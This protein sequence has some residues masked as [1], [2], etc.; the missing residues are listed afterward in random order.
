MQTL[1]DLPAL[2]IADLVRQ[3]PGTERPAV[4]GLCLDVAEGE[5]F[6]LLGPNG[7]GKTTTISIVC[8]LLQVDHGAVEVVGHSAGSHTVQR[9][10]GFVPQDIALYDTLT[11]RENLRFFGAMYDLSGKDLNTR[12]NELLDRFGLLERADDQIRFFSGGMKRRVNIMAA[13]LHGPRLLILDEPTVG[14]DVQ[15]RALINSHLSE[16]NRSGTTILYTSH[17]LD[18][19]ER[20]CSR[21]AIMD[22][23]SIIAM[24]T[25]AQLLHAH[26]CPDLESVFL[27]LTGRTLRDHTA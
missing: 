14:I 18:E 16:L 22:H 17:H 19:A 2:H 1:T 24:G 9:L 23:G 27:K 26:E 25:P 3:Y 8:G 20:L 12:I 6:G 13:L 11:A 10:I 4:N 21:L 7:A 15:S 5:F